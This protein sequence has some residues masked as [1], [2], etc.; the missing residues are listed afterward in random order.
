MRLR[1]GMTGGLGVHSMLAS[2]DVEMGVGRWGWGQGH[3]VG[4][5]ERGEAEERGGAVEVTYI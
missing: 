1:G 4:Q 5:G 3:R 2:Y